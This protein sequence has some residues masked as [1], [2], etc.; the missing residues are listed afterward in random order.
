M[1]PSSDPSDRAPDDSVTAE[2]INEALRSL[3]LSD[4]E[5]RGSAPTRRRGRRLGWVA[6]FGLLGAAAVAMP[7]VR[8]PRVAEVA[9]VEAVVVA[10]RDS[11]DVLLD[12]SGTV[13]PRQRVSISAEVPGVIREVCVEE[14]A[15]VRKGDVLIRLDDARFRADLEQARA[16]LAQAEA[17][18]DKL[19]AGALPEE[20]DQARAALAEAEA[21]VRNLRGEVDRAARA[22]VGGGTSASEMHKL[23]TE[24]RVAEED[25]R[26]QKSRLKVLEKGAREEDLRAAQS[27]VDRCRGNLQKAQFYCDRTT[28]VAP[29]GGTVLERKAEVGEAVHPEFPSAPLC[30][31]ADLGTM[32][33]EVDVQERDLP[34]LKQAGA[35]QVIPEAY[36]DRAYRGRVGRMRPAVNKSGAVNVR[37]TVLDGDDALLADMNCRVKFLEG[38]TPADAGHVWV[39]ESALRQEGG[40]SVVY[41]FEGG[42]A[43]R[44]VVERGT[45]SEGSVE[46][47]SGLKPGDVV[48]LPAPGR[49]LSEGMPVRPRVKGG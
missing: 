1:L 4:A 38:S 34:K 11:S 18:R 3:Q 7:W 39:P 13:V 9:E 32:E 46:V 16:A 12:R 24:L 49:P 37:V 27:D 40:Q 36:P 43:R 17:Q 20:L 22:L 14:G 15:K 47:R 21:K 45:A 10:G 5:R 30:V 25:V 19:K 44:R 33:A 6:A 42:V 2:Q 41:V 48:L 31:L 8:A 23:R 28:I 29:C 26:C 35:C